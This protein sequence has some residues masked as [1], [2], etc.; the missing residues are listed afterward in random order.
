MSTYFVKVFSLVLLE[1][2]QDWSRIRTD[3]TGVLKNVL[4]LYESKHIS[5]N[6]RDKIMVLLCDIVLNDKLLKI[7]G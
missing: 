1:N 2:G 3:T 7:Y 4:V 5:K 6:C